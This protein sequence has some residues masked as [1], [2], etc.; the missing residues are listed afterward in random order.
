MKIFTGILC[1]LL[2]AVSVNAQTEM[3]E[4]LYSRSLKDSIFYRVIVPEGWNAGQKLPVLYTIKYGMMDGAYIAAQLHYFKS[5]HYV[6][7]NALVVEIQ[8]DM[9]EIG[10]DYKTGLLT[11]AGMAF[12]GCIKN[13][14]IPAVEKKYNT[15]AFRAYIG[16]SFAASY[17]NYWFQYEPD[18]FSGYILLAPEK[19]GVDYTKAGLDDTG[20]SLF[21]L[22]ENT[23]KFY[24][25]R[26]TF[27]YAAVGALDMPRRRA[28]AKEVIAKLKLLD[29]AQFYAK[30]DSIP[31]AGHTSILTAAIQPALEFIFQLDAPDINDNSQQNA[32]QQLIGEENKLEKI[33]GTGLDK[34]YTGYVPFLQLALKNKDTASVV[35]IARYFNT[36]QTKAYNTRNLGQW[37]LSAGLVQ[38]A[39]MYYEHAIA[40]I[41]KDHMKEDWEPVV[42]S[43]CYYTLG[44]SIYKTQPDT[45]WLLVQKSVA[46]ADL[47]NKPGSKN[48]DAYFFAGQYAIDHQTHVKEGLQYLLKYEQFRHNALDVIHTDYKDIFLYTGKAY[49]LLH[50]TANA[51]AYFH[52]VLET[53]PANKK[54]KE[55]LAK[56]P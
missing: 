22:D 4:K 28:Y 31:N 10:F 14:I 29:S 48:I 17:A 52:R 23:I 56:L 38:Q 44:A 43:D 19:V 36:G 16:H 33:Y 53:D 24:N 47:K 39:K 37:C 7:P 35:K 1:G 51:R 15:S 6:M 49:T 30:Y 32:Y 20:P 12:A 46:V 21:K 8:A 5:A 34:D 54:A 18:T 13:E 26:T 2:F 3:Q 40:T 9:D 42:L 25:Q 41:L 45:A 27:Y 11:P 55:A 50:D